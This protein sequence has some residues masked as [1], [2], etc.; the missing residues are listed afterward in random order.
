MVNRSSE[1]KDYQQA[2][3]HYWTLHP[4]IFDIID[5]CELHQNHVP[6]ELYGHGELSIELWLRPTEDDAYDLR[7][8]HVS[9]FDVHALELHLGGFTPSLSLNIR[10]I[11]KD[12]LE[13]LNYAVSGSLGS[14]L[15]FYCKDFEAKLEEAVLR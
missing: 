10:S 9:F 14:T 6:D 1:I 11:R 13:G 12:Q 8:L 15:S 2:V 5:R 7:R 3:D 4:D